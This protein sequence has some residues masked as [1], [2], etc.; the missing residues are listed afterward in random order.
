MIQVSK[1][2]CYMRNSVLSLCPTD[3]VGVDEDT[4]AKIMIDIL[5][6]RRV[7]GTIEPTRERLLYYLQSS[8]HPTVR[9]AELLVK[10]ENEGLHNADRAELGILA[11]GLSGEYANLVRLEVLNRLSEKDRAIL[12][13]R[14]KM[15]K[16]FS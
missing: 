4:Y 14:R 5:E 6:S 9:Q 13:I 10:Q 11:R 2:I 16:A 7:T 1:V 3:D 12:D 8:G 15:D